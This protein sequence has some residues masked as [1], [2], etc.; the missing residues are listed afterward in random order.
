MY[1]GDGISVCRADGR[2]RRRRGERAMDNPESHKVF[3]PTLH[4]GLQTSVGSLGPWA[5]QGPVLCV[6]H[7]PSEAGIDLDMRLDF[8][9]DRRWV[10]SRRWLSISTEGRRMLMR[11]SMDRGWVEIGRVARGTRSDPPVRPRR[12]RAG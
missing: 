6:C 7:W 10:R 1:Q 9:L 5:K 11:L 3:E 4:D 12:C 2:R 8:D